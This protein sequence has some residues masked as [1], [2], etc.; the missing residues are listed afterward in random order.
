MLTLN[1][2][3]ILP[4]KKE[5]LREFIAV[6][7]ISKLRRQTDPGSLVYLGV[8]LGVGWGGGGGQPKVS[9]GLHQPGP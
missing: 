3:F 4:H 7:L 8:W 9:L 6:L 1:S 5:I 2:F